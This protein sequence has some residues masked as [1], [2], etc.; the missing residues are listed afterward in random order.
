[1]VAH[2]WQ[3]SLNC[4]WTYSIYRLS[5]RQNFSALPSWRVLLRDFLGCALSAVLILNKHWLHACI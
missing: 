5:C 1:M 4:S 2:C 3:Q